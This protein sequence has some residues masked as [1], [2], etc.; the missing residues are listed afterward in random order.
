METEVFRLAP[1]QV[2]CEHG[3]KFQE[4]DVT[5]DLYRCENCGAV[6]CLPDLTEYRKFCGATA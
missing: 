2:A 1:E 5:R 3:P 4:E 6:L